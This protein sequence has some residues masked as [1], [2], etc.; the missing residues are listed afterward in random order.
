MSYWV[1]VSDLLPDGVIDVID[2]RFDPHVAG[3]ARLVAMAEEA[4]GEEVAATPTRS[5]AEAALEVLW[6]CGCADDGAGSVS[7]LGWHV[8][9]VIMD[10][11]L[12]L[13]YIGMLSIQKVV[14]MFIENSTSQR[15]PTKN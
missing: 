1:S 7:E 6:A 11:V 5:R 9:R 3:A 14:S 12:I 13:L 15:K 4:S 8:F 2:G 10:M